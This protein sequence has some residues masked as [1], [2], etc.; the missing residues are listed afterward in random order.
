MEALWRSWETDIRT[1][2]APIPNPT[3]ESL[4]LV[5]EDKCPAS[6]NGVI[7]GPGQTRLWGEKLNV[8]MKGI[9][10][11]N[12]LKEALSEVDEEARK[13]LRNDAE[14]KKG[15]EQLEGKAVN[16]R[17]LLPHFSRPI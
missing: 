14:L 15:N 8:W 10:F 9:P 5:V 1:K 13:E 16:S 11:N 4:T 12:S 7:E 17:G 3:G 2:E 6:Y